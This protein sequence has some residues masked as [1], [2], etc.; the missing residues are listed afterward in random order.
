MALNHVAMADYIIA[1]MRQ[2][3]SSKTIMGLMGHAMA[4][5][6]CANTEVRFSW[7]GMAGLASDPVTQYVTTDVVGDINLVHTRTNKPFPA[8]AH[9]AEQIRKECANFTIGPAP[10]WNVPRITFNNHSPPPIVPTR[11]NKQLNSMRKLCN[12]VITMYKTY[13]NSTP[14]MGTHLAFSAPS[15]AGAIMVEIF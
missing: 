15:G 3:D 2:G 8:C 1:K 4:E 13:I 7:H 11:T 5:Y 10:T 12:W 14:L 9:L 6:L